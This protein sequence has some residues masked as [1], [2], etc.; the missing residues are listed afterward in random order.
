MLLG[1]ARER[2]LVTFGGS[3]SVRFLASRYASISY[4][5]EFRPLILESDP[6]LNQTCIGFQGGPPG[7]VN[8]CYSWTSPTPVLSTSPSTYTVQITDPNG[9]QPP[10]SETVTNSYR[11]RW[12]YAT[13]LSPIG[14]DLKPAPYHRW[15]PVLTGSVGFL[16]A[17]QDIPL[18]KTSNFNFTFA[19]GA[20]IEHVI[21]PGKA[22]RVEYRYNHISND[23][24]GAQNPGIDSGVLHVAYLFGR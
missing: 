24:I 3:Y 16:V 19:F 7:L 12:T 13:G 9:V 4:Y 5:A 8:A 23:Y 1:S 14:Y 11:R 22:L 10:F 21:A 20:G 2:K 15:H 6:I 18:E 17:T